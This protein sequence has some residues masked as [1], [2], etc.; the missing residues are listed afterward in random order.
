MGIVEVEGSI[1]D[2]Y[3]CDIFLRY[4]SYIKFQ[5]LQKD[6]SVLS[7]KSRTLCVSSTFQR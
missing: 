1:L 5:S 7:T 2:D 6:G 4:F 3:D